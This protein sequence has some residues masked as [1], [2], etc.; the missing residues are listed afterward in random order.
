LDYT[1]QKCVSIFFFIFRFVFEQDAYYK[2]K[3]PL[4]KNTIYT[5]ITEYADPSHVFI[6]V[7]MPIYGN[8]IFFFE[9]RFK[10]DLI[11]CYI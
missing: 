1:N 10:I 7:K 3:W 2:N 11:R 9:Y 6:N 4:D 8:V 5:H